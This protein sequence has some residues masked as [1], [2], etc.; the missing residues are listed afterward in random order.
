MYNARLKEVERGVNTY[1]LKYP[2][3]TGVGHRHSLRLE[4]GREE[5][6]YAAGLSYNNVAGAMKGS[7]RNTFNGN[8][9]LSYKLNNITFQND[10]Q[11][12]F[13]KSKNSP[14]GTF[15]DFAKVNACLLYTSIS[16]THINYA[17]FLMTKPSLFWKAFMTKMKTKKI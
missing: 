6:R 16:K 2:V 10:L 9:F 11:V 15:S 1:W 4:G 12:S 13:N 8:M 17:Y 7:E 5:F 3:R 14:Y